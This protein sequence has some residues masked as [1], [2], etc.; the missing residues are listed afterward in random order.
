MVQFTQ[1]SLPLNL[2]LFVLA[3]AAVWFAGARVTRY[4]ESISGI[5]GIGH[6]ALGMM[7]LAGITS[8]PEI[9]VASTA[10]M[11]GNAD[12]AVN[13][14]FGS[15][16]L[17]IA[18][19]AAVDF[20]V[21]REALTSVVP[22]PAV[23]LQGSLNVILIAIAAGAMVVGDYPVLGIGLGPWILIFAYVACVW[24]LS[25]AGGRL[26]WLAAQNNR[27]DRD[28]IGRHRRNVAKEDGEEA[29]RPIVWKTVGAAAIILVAG[30]LLAQT[31]EAIA[32][33]T[34]LGSSFVGFVL[35][36]MATALPELST[37]L[38]A[39]RR[40]LATLAISDILGT[41]LINTA[42]I[43]L[44]DL[45]DRGDPVLGRV[46]AFSVFGAL[47]AIVLNAI[48]MAGLSERRDRAFLRMGYDSILVIIVYVGAIVLLYGLRADT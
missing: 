14:L 26:P 18:L 30:F 7:L 27:V 32:E 22:E 44:V 6:A 29:L 24:T 28:L 48:F 25:R 21:G 33:Q 3:G 5:T 23:I 20:F 37:A 38:A 9:G 10:S 41:S 16:A 17:Q 15:V 42:L 43:F 36:S 35:V 31:G 47:L 4:A 1:L 45:L 34:G 11:A 46:G 19:L 39:A 8:L 13:N 2:A 12:L 40:G